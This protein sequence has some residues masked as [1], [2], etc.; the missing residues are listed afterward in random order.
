MALPHEEGNA[1]LAARASLLERLRGIGVAAE[2]RTDPDPVN[3]AEPLLFHLERNFGAAE[4]ERRPAGEGLVILRSA[5]ARGEAEAIAAEV[6]KLVAGGAD[7]AEIAI[8]LRDPA[9]R[10]PLVA[11][12]L[13]SYG[14]AAALE[15]ELPV[16][17]TSVGGALVALLDAELGSGARERPAPLPARPLRGHPAGGRLAR[18]GGSPQAGAG[19]GGGAAAL[20][21][22][23]RRAAGRPGA[24]R[25]GRRR[26]A[27]RA[28]RRGRPHRRNDGLATAGRARGR[29]AAGARRGAGAARRGVDLGGARRARRAGRSWR[30]APA[31]LAATIEALRFR[32]WSGPVEGRVRIA[33]PRRL[34]AARFDHVFVASLQDGEFPRRDG[35]R[36]P[37]LSDAQRASL[38]L[39]PRRDPE[40]E[41]RYLFH[42]CVALPR[43]RLFLSYRDS[44]EDGGAEARSPLLDEVRRLLDPPP[45]ERSPDPVEESLTIGR[46]LTQ[47]VHPVAEAPSE[48]ELARAIA[49][50]GRRR[51][52]GRPADPG[53]RRRPGGGPRR[54]ADRV[55]QGRRGRR[56]RPR[57]ARQ[58]GGDRLAGR[59]PRLRRHDPGGL[60]PLLL[61]LVRRP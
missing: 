54:D 56:P 28:G 31:E 3:T 20:A 33:D 17:A 51:R 26:P 61:P 19:R 48:D 49:A 39:D 11:S 35:D 53:R 45:D 46:D 5:G 10:G 18:E 22:E 15:V 8:V 38:G 41:E 4:P 55:R 1:A 30:P 42:A 23:A 25:G 47:V 32:A 16:V 36:D 29:P 50:H 13:E 12:V 6:A 9:R 21:G 34:R 40:D 44:D 57:A 37:F 27:G 52:P 59:G 24:A 58:P 43:R 60:R 2:E 14:I 7:P